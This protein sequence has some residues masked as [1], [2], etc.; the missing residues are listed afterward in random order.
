MPR[1]GGPQHR[2]K[3]RKEEETRMD[4]DRNYDEDEDA[5]AY[6]NIS[7]ET[8]KDGSAVVRTE[9]NDNFD[10]GI[11]NEYASWEHGGKAPK[12]P[13][14]HAGVSHIGIS[15]VRVRVYVNGKERLIN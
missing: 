15:G 9:T 12:G 5:Q 10:Q 6:Q 8:F 14:M 3:C 2:R 7:V 13:S 11:P 4:T 1:A